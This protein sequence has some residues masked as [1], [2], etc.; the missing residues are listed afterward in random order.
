MV[1]A[2]TNSHCRL[3]AAQKSHDVRPGGFLSHLISVSRQ[4]SHACRTYELNGNH[5]K[6]YDL[7][8]T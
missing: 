3:L 5:G 4:I 2:S 8:C 7:V 1:A 6:E